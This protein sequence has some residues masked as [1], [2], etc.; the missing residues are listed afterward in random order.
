MSSVG[1]ATVGTTITYFCDEGYKLTGGDNTAT[2]TSN[3]EW[4]SQIPRCSSG[5]STLNWEILMSTNIMLT[6]F[7]WKRISFKATINGSK[8]FDNS[9]LIKT[10]IPSSV[11]TIHDS[12]RTSF[13]TLRDNWV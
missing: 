8:D 9:W 3:G 13:L 10:G 12:I 2:C 1:R 7:I 11:E 5:K 4:S 6:A